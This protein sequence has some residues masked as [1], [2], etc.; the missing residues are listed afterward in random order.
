MNKLTVEQHYKNQPRT[1]IIKIIVIS[2]IALAVIWSAST[3]QF[4]PVNKLGRRISV[5]ILKG[6]VTPSQDQLFNF[7]NIGVP[8]LLLETLAIGF[9]GTLIG[10]IISIP[11]AF[12][13]ARNMTNRFFSSV[14]ITIISVIRT[15]PAIVYG[16][17]FIRVTG[18]GPFAG[19]LTLSLTSVGMIT[20]LY[21]E[22]IED[23]DKGIIEALDASGCT[24]FQKIRYGIIPQLTSNFIST[25][26]YRF[27]INIKDAT[28]LGLV[29]AGG[30]GASLL[31]AMSE[32]RW[33][34]V[35]A[36]LFGLIILVLIVEK[37]STHIRKTI[38]TGESKS[39]LSKLKKRIK[40]QKQVV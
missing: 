21:I 27:E 3:I 10:S 23:L 25:A 6:I 7:T 20:K 16:L 35:G 28:I 31:F 12:L 18:P 8:Y 4:T 9:L 33:N 26:I 34:D 2:I 19:V 17:M 30:I 36:I 29:G 15:F 13:S 22:S 11:F 39:F 1:Y 38:T 37:I 24:T 14:G 40:K 32:S 5:L